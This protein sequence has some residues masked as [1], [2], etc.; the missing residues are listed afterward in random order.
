MSRLLFVLVSLLAFMPALHA[1]PSAPTVTA[2]LRCLGANRPVSGLFLP[3]VREGEAP[4][5]IS[6]PDNYL[7]GPYVY[8]G[9]AQLDFLRPITDAERT[10][11][12]AQLPPGS[13]ARPPAFVPAV[14]V[15][16]PTDGGDLLVLFESARDNTLRAGVLD[17][18]FATVPSGTYSAWSLS[19][20]PLG[21]QLGDTRTLVSPGHRHLI[22][23]AENADGYVDLA[24]FGQPRDGQPQRLVGGRHHHRPDIRQLIFLVASPA[25]DRVTVRVI[26]DVPPAPGVQTASR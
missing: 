14:S 16:L 7:A 15:T 24:V 13:T 21:L 3:P 20:A 2:R 12:L 25:G 11:F 8:T 26:N 4:R 18:S 22:R 9:P 5:P 23:L 19:P 10:A 17:Y 1:Q 6:V